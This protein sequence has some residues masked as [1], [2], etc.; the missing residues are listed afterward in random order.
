MTAVTN[1][2][3]NSGAVEVALA[4]SPV[5]DANGRIV[6]SASIAISY[7]IVTDYIVSQRLLQL[8][9]RRRLPHRRPGPTPSKPAIR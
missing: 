8:G 1:V 6:G 3:S 5:R 2:T 4:V 7:S 9:G